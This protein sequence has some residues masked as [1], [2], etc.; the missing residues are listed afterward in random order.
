MAADGQEPSIREF[1]DRGTLWLLEAPENLRGVAA[2][3]A[4]GHTEKR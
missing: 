1:P 3:L 2:L 4:G